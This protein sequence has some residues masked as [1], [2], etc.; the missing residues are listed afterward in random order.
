[1]SGSGGNEP[2]PGSFFLLLT[3]F[4][5][6]GRVA[7]FPPA[8]VGSVFGGKRASVRISIHAPVAAFIARL[9]SSL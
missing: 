3:R 5:E 2:S 8:V 6:F 4:P 1:M 7:I 9:R